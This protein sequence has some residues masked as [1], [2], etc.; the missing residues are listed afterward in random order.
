MAALVAAEQAR[1]GQ[2]RRAGSHFSRI[3]GG[4]LGDRGLATPLH[5]PTQIK[6]GQG[7]SRGA[8]AGGLGA[9]IGPERVTRADNE[10]VKIGRKFLELMPPKVC[11]S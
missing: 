4:K 7:G 10:G 6:V 11:H 8:V 5:P 1:V 2:G 3:T 9:A